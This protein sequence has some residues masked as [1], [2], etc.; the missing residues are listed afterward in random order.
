[1]KLAIFALALAGCCATGPN[2]AQPEAADFPSAPEGR[3]SPCVRSC[4]NRKALACLEAALEHDCI[5]VCER[6]RAAKLYD[7]TCAIA[8]K[9]QAEMLRCGVRCLP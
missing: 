9:T 2:G 3:V 1:M 7:P 8:A 5:P 6:A 4:V